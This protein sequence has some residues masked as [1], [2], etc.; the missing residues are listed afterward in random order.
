[1][2]YD[3]VPE[4]PQDERRMILGAFLYPTGYHV[5]A[6]RH[7]DVPS[8][9]G[10]NLRHFVEVA[11]TA[12]RAKFDFLF[13]PDAAA[14]RGTDLEALSRTAIRYV[15]QFEPV[16]LISA[17]AAVTHRIGLT[18][19]MSSTYQEP[20]FVARAIASLD[21]LSGGRAG[22]NLVTSQSPYE[23]YNFG[24]SVQPS[25]A[26]RYERAHEFADVV[27][28]LWDSWADDAFVRDKDSG[29]FFRPDAMTTLDHKGPHFQV[30]G[31]LNIPRSP[32]GRPVLLQAGASEPGRELAARTAEVVFTAQ[33][34]FA[35][36]RAFRADVLGRLARHGR[37]SA[38]VRVLCGAFV[39][40]G[41]TRAEA[42]D[43]V[44][45]LQDLIHPAVGLSLLGSEL[46]GVDLSGYPLD[47]PLPPLPPSNTAKGRFTLLT[48]MARREKLT[49]RR[50]YQHV[51]GGRGHWHLTGSVSEVAD[52]LQYWFE[53][54]AADGFFIMPPK[55]PGS[56]DDFALQVVPELR[57]RGLF[58]TEYTGRTLR[59]HLGLRR[60]F[61]QSPVGER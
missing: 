17:M 22:W 29:R 4:M 20:Y 3:E 21:H 42:E 34:T 53:E 56:L 44:A 10:V 11:Q 60:P 43:K 7:P 25:H 41:R 32:Q 5:A 16:S 18:V 13:L 47:G 9:A 6:W 28:G 39:T 58:R 24:Y 8:D 38:D 54:G 40:V 12:E 57:R 26:E 61:R 23:A 49:I 1:M 52:E 46:G 2:T 51:A 55:L 48:E 31:P 19:T 30:R 35:D 14:M 45:E 59:E 36:A 33:P 27:R 50:L 37:E 15:A